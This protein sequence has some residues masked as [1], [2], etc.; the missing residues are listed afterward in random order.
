MFCREL[1]LYS[2]WDNGT[3]SVGSTTKNVATTLMR[4]IYVP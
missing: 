2:S 4:L 3:R 1:Y